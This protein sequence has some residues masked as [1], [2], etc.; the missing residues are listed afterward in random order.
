M[1]QLA[2]LCQAVRVAELSFTSYAVLGLLSLR[3]WTAY[4]IELQARRSL[5]FVAPR[6]RTALYAEPK[7][8]VTR[9][10]ATATP[11]RRGQR[12][13]AVYEISDAGRDEFRSW[14]KTPAAFPQL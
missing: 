14:F 11:E 12:T 5:N 6:A 9:G 2:I 13:V 1:Y 10:L 4:E 8:L 7:K 3:P